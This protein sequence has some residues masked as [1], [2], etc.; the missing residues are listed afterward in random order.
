[1]ASGWLG[2]IPPPPGIE[3]NIV[4]PATQLKANIGLHI[5]CLTLVT[6]SVAIRVYM[7]VIITKAPFGLDDCNVTISVLS[8]EDADNFRRPLCACMG[9]WISLKLPYRLLT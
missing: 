8:R 2:A 4:N 3:P 5:V 7:R 1:M 9:V 6:S